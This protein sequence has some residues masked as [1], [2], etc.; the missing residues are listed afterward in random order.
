MTSRRHPILLQ[1]NPCIRWCQLDDNNCQDAQTS[2]IL[3]DD[4]HWNTSPKSV[5]AHWYP[6][7]PSIQFKSHGLERPYK[8]FFVFTWSLRCT[9]GQL[10]QWSKGP[11]QSWT[12]RSCKECYRINQVVQYPIHT[13][14]LGCE[15]VVSIWS[16][17]LQRMAQCKKHPQ[18]K[19]SMPTYNW[20]CANIR[21]AW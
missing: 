7:V 5:P 20:R 10:I 18:T 1:P 16:S 2:V 6:Q 13:C 15:S 4:A 19:Y 11:I 9:T 17:T 21:I 3:S 14:Q 8:S 12:K